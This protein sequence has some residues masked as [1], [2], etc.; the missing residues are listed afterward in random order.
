MQ[1][2]IKNQI[3]E[4]L[5][6]GLLGHGFKFRTGQRE[7]VEAICNAYYEDPEGTVVIDAPTGTGKSIIAMASSMV[8]AQLGHRGYLIASDISLQDQYESDFYRLGIHWPSVKGVDN[9][10]CEVNGL[11]FSIGDCKIKGLGYEL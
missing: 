1:N 2:S 3:D 8:L 5:E 10:T 11:P 7:T 6:K 9:Y 4:I